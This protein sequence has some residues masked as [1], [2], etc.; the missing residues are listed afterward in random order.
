MKNGIGMVILGVGFSVAQAAVMGRI[1]DTVMQPRALMLGNAY[2]ASGEDYFG[3][4]YNPAALGQKAEVEV[5]GG[6]WVLGSRGAVDAVR[7]F[8]EILKAPHSH[9]PQLFQDWITRRYGQ[10]YLARTQW[11]GIISAPGWALAVIPAD[12]QVEMGFHNW[13]VPTV[14]AR[15]QGDST[16]ALGWGRLL[17]FWPGIGKVHM[18]LTSR[19]FHRYHWHRWV[20]LPDLINDPNQFNRLHL[21]QGWLMEVDWGLLVTPPMDEVTAARW[22]RWRWGTVVRNLGPIRGG[23]STVPSNPRVMDLGW[24]WDLPPWGIWQLRLLGDLKNLGWQPY[25]W[26]NHWALGMELDWRMRSWWWGRYSLGFRGGY[27]AF[28]ASF[29]MGLGR[30]ELGRFVEPVGIGSH[31]KPNET[32]WIQMSLQF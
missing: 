12:F 26:E 32:Y 15:V 1:P 19:I 3:F 16:L 22:G 29:F 2:V 6:F 28:G 18:G 30:L 10:A 14:E 13:G 23:Q 7:E 20:A 5:D 21:D 25:V 31:R 9:Q 27:P 4:L 24:R 8:Q 11:H 17:G